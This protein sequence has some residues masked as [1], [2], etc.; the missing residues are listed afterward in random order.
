MSKVRFLVMLAAAATALAGCGDRQHRLS[1]F[2]Y[3]E[4][5]A[6]AA[7]TLS[8]VPQVR[9]GI[10]FLAIDRDTKE[11]P[12]FDPAD[13]HAT[14]GG[15]ELSIASRGYS[16]GADTCFMTFTAPATTPLNGM[17]MVSDSSLEITATFDLSALQMRELNHPTWRFARGETVAIQWSPPSDF[18]DVKPGEGPSM[19][20]GTSASDIPLDPTLVPPDLVTFTI[21][22]SYPTGAKE[23]YIDFTP[24]QYGD[25]ALSCINAYECVA[26]QNRYVEFDAIVE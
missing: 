15:I 12:N 16:D 11:C 22:S 13:F 18:D 1:E 10:T 19:G 21:P 8:E 25:A 26:Y 9:V 23:G 24:S 4:L 7:T 14:F 6:S 5:R 20:L 3:Y 17:V 2:D